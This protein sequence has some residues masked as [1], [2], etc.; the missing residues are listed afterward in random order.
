MWLQ[1]VLINTVIVMGG[2]NERYNYLKSVESFRF[3]HYG[4]DELPEM[5]EDG[6]LLQ[7]HA[8]HVYIVYND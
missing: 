7:L 3:D 1:Y 2:A 5:H 8:N 4:W 6:E